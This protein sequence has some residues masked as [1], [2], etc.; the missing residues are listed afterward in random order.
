M[1][2]IK[3]M[4]EILVATNNPGKYK[5][6]KEALDPH[7]IKAVFPQDIGINLDPEETGQTM[8]ENAVLKVSAFQKVAPDMTIIADDAGIE[9]EALNW[10]PGV[11]TRR[12]KD[13]KTRMTDEE[14]I[15]YYLEKLSE[16][17]YEKR[18]A[19]FRSVIALAEPNKEIGLFNGVLNGKILEQPKDLRIEGLP[20]QSLFYVP[21]W[22]LTMGEVY[23]M[24]RS[25]KIKYPT[26][27][28]I[29]L[30][31]LIERLIIG[32]NYIPL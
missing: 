27:R 4:I 11:H 15:S 32:S 14:I 21:E 28:E 12:W 26:H 25:E 30:E 9:I 29:A 5:Q 7:G 13:K 19:R 8:E 18:N 24:P 23:L 2:K 3:H 1:V 17:P 16:V 22:N 6:I 20:F 31:K 10:E